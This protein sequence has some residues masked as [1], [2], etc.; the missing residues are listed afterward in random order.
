MHYSIAIAVADFADDIISRGAITVPKFHREL[1]VGLDQIA[2][3]EKT[4]AFLENRIEIILDDACAELRLG[5]LLRAAQ[6]RADCGR[7]GS[8]SRGARGRGHDLLYGDTN[9]PGDTRPLSVA[10]GGAVD[11]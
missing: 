1:F 2:G 10:C 7:A 8:S 11:P 9:A 4:S 5:V 6:M 3:N